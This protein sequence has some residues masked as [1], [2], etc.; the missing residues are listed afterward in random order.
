MN[1]FIPALLFIIVGMFFQPAYPQENR[2][3]IWFSVLSPDGRFFE[4]LR[5]SDI[6]LFIGKDEAKI[7]SF[8]KRNNSLDVLILIDASASQERMLPK[9][10]IAAET[11]IDRVLKKD[12]DRV[13]IAK[14]TGN[15]DLVQDMTSDYVL[16]KD[17][18]NKIKF[19]PPPGFIRG[20]IIVSQSPPSPASTK[21]STTSIWDSLTRASNDLAQ[22]K[23]RESRRVILLISDGINTSG[24]RKLHDAVASS[25]KDGVSIFAIGIGDNFYYGVN[26]GSLKK[27]TEQTGGLMIVPKKTSDLEQFFQ[28][29]EQ[30]LRKCYEIIFSTQPATSNELQRT[31]IEISNPDLRNKDLRLV[32][33]AGYSSSN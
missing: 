7:D 16:A 26:S 10:K 21:S 11:F 33:P 31:K 6:R 32:E 20:G 18:L 13:A 30:T 19:E 24:D 4:G 2:A 23:T 29:T 14:L 5:S 1:K 17:A 8:A 9:E 22:D 27:I 28:R 15:M 25:A 3:T 12:T